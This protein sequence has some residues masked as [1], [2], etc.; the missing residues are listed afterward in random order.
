MARIRTI[1]PE[2]WEDEKI[3]KLPIPCRLFFIGCWNF[4]D[5]NGIIRA[6]ASYLKSRIFP[7]DDNLRI[8]E[9]QKYIDA[10]LNARM[11]VP[12]IHEGESYY[13]IRTFRSHQKFDARYPNYIINKEIA[14]EFLTSI[15]SEYQEDTTVNQ[16]PSGDPVGTQRVPATGGGRGKGI[17]KKESANADKKEAEASSCAKTDYEK[18]K[19]WLEN[20]TPFCANVKNFPHQISE[21]EFFKLKEK[22]TGKEISET[23]MQIE[24]RKDLRK[25]YTNLYLTT[26]NWAKKNHGK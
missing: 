6:S 18:F 21:K 8:T 16:S 19:I 1:K 13:V 22:F 2:F 12:I 25:R 24:N 3:G 15:Y 26:L 5:D 9:V 11:L 20:N 4:A 23:I 14:A 17:D 7:Y 10:L